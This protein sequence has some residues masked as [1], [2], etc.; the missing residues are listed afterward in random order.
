MKIPYSGTIHH[1]DLQILSGDIHAP[2]T[3]T[4]CLPFGPG[5]SCS[6][7][8]MKCL[9]RGSAVSSYMLKPLVSLLTPHEIINSGFPSSLPLLFPLIDFRT[10]VFPVSSFLLLWSFSFSFPNSFSVARSLNNNV[11]GSCMFRPL[12]TLHSFLGDISLSQLLLTCYALPSKYLLPPPLSL[13]LHSSFPLPIIG[14][15]SQGVL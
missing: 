6:F 1:A 15:F 12:L 11:L 8:C 2:P 9:S 3:S 7:V 13:G 10:F 14:P 5:P 4:D